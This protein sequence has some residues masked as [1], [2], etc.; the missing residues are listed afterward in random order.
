MVTMDIFLK[1]AL[2]SVSLLILCP[3][4]CILAPLSER[5]MEPCGGS[6]TSNTQL[7]LTT[8]PQKISEFAQIQILQAKSTQICSES[9]TLKDNFYAERINDQDL[10]SLLDNISSLERFPKIP[11]T[12]SEPKRFLQYLKD[13]YKE[14]SAAVVFVERMLTDET[15]E[16]IT[17]T[18][19]RRMSFFTEYGKLKENLYTFLCQLNIAVKNFD[20]SIDNFADTDTIDKSLRSLSTTERFN[21]DYIIL[22]DVTRLFNY[23]TKCFSER[24]CFVL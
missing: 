8:I 2:S 24:T 21:R 19:S 12:P 18:S 23:F 5:I 10:Q 11:S 4:R 13:C 16:S 1:I 14:T 9:K 6:R 22:R 7:V 17:S 15:R 3:T 20:S